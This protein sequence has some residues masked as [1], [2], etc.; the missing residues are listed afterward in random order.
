VFRHF[1]VNN[2]KFLLPCADRAYF[3]SEATPCFR[4]VDG[5]RAGYIPVCLPLGTCLRT[6][7][8]GQCG[9]TIQ[10]AEHWLIGFVRRMDQSRNWT[11][12]LICS[13]PQRRASTRARRTRSAER[14]AD[15]PVAGCGP[16]VRAGE[17]W[18][19]VPYPLVSPLARKRMLSRNLEPL[20]GQQLAKGS[21]N[22]PVDGN[23]FNYR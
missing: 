18:A 6:R 13:P 8:P 4:S 12:S 1:I 16:L 19:V 20:S 23:A 7:Q 14:P 5:K 3:A 10:T 17:V 9:T 21:S 11:T 15:G 22:V 2:I